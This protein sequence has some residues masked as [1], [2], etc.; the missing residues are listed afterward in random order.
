MKLRGQKWIYQDGNHEIIVENAWSW[1]GH[2]QERIRING[3]TVLEQSGK[4]Y[5]APKWTEA[6]QEPW[7][8][9]L[10]DDTLSIQYLS[11]FLKVHAR[12]LLGERELEPV[13][14]LEGKWVSEG[15]YWPD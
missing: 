14:Y 7:L 3:E 11:G 10:G 1:S 6:H 13:D 15:G 12:V 2:S 5:I 9:Q 8:T 4:G